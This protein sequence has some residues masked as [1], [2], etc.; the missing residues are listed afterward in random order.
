MQ[1]GSYE[2]TY[3]RHPTPVDSLLGMSVRGL[4]AGAK[5]SAAVADSFYLYCWGDTG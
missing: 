5:H 3:L 1:C 4:A 2:R